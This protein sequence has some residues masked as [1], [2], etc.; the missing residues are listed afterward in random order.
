MHKINNS[1]K[2]CII[3]FRVI[4]STNILYQ[5]CTKATITRKK[6]LVFQINKV[7]QDLD[8]SQNCLKASGSWCSHKEISVTSK[9]GIVLKEQRALA[10][11]MH[12][13]SFQKGTLSMSSCTL[14]LL[15]A[16][17]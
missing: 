14:F 17:P 3:S 5:K 4:V 10:N 11:Q 13:D 15:R 8:E 6:G 1:G 2:K 12:L 16:M 9:V 7:S